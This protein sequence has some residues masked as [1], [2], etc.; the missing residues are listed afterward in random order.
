M[1]DRLGIDELVVTTGC[2]LEDTFLPS[3]VPV[4]TLVAKL[5]AEIATIKE[6]T[7]MGVKNGGICFLSLKN[8]FFFIF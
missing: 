8:T 6:K 7:A 4:A 2:E 3:C 5:A 1:L